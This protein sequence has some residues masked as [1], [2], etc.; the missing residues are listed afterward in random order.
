MTDKMVISASIVLYNE[1]IT[2]LTNTVNSFLNCKLPKRLFLIDNTKESRFKNVF[3]LPE[4]E[5]I[6]IKK[7]IGFGAAH[8]KILEKIKE[9]SSYHLILNPDV[10]FKP[11]GILTL[12]NELKNNSYVGVISPKVIYPSGELQFTCRKHPIFIEHIYRRLGMFKT[13]TQKQEYRDQD[14][15]RPFNPDFVHGCFMLF[16]TQEFV[17]VNGFDERYFMYLEDADICRKLAQNQQK[18]LYYP[19]V[20]IEHKHQKGSAKKFNLLIHHLS[21][22]IKYH[23]KWKN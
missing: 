2:D 13:H 12:I 23:K 20:I 10:V 18:V 4:V 22:A 1:D 14:L 7:N 21:S 19:K 16:K 9:T 11:D 3:K 8:N 17:N 6:P 5:Y 15:S